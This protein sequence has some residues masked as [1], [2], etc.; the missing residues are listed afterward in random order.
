MFELSRKICREF[1]GRATAWASASRLSSGAS[2]GTA[3]GS[4]KAAAINQQSSHWPALLA[5][6]AITSMT[7]LLTPGQASAQV[8]QSPPLLPLEVTVFPERD[9][10]SITGFAA[11]ADVVVQL[12]RG[13]VVSDAVGR[14]DATGFLEVNHPG[15]VCWRNV[16][17]DIVPGD[18]VRV[19]YRD[20]N[21]NRLNVPTAVAGSGAATTTQ[22][23]TATQA[24]DAGNGTV[25]IRGRAQLANGSRIPLNRLEVRIINPDFI[26]APGSRIGRRDIRADSVGGRVDGTN[27]NPIAGTSGTLAYDGTATTFTAVFSGLNA[28]ER[29]LVVEGQTR[30]MG[31]QQTSAAGDRLGMTIYEVGE[32]GGPGMGGCPPGPNGVIAPKN[33]TPP[34]PYL[35]A[36]LLDAANPVNQPSLK[37]VTVFPERDFISIAGFPAGTDLQ[38]VVRRGNSGAPVVGTARGIVGSGGLFEVNHPGGVCWTGQTPNIV[39]GDWIDV[40]QVVS[41]GFSAGQTQRVIDAK[42]T[43]PAFVT[44]TGQVQVDGSAVDA[45]GLPLSLG[46]MEQRI[47]N[48]DFK[49][50]R[51]GRRDIRADTDGG[52]V[53]NIPGGTGRLLRTGTGAEWRAIYTGLNAAEQRVAVAGQSRAMAWL[54]T[55]NNGDRFGMTIFESGEL[56]GPGFGGCPATGSAQIPIT[57]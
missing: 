24:V 11:N 45:G 23:V 32:L 6:T 25:L 13:A 10:T 39:P 35:P 29:R 4:T 43:R 53:E 17:P 51:I 46:L 3:D 30:V 37:D 26:G 9:F 42:I 19:T 5:L 15:G 8:I 38:V 55:N 49:D 22:N 50:T 14:T 57:P 21:H 16:T 28:D 47:I 41:L 44:S 56:G 52:R 40:F 48:P 27:G 33:P 18:V 12:R 54:S 2:R 31:W 34:V 36:N 1:Q 7:V 20:T